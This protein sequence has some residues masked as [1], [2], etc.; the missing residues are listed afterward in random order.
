M[1]NLKYLLKEAG[2][3]W[4]IKGIIMEKKSSKERY[5]SKEI[6]NFSKKKKW[7]FSQSQNS[8]PWFY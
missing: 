8:L 5:T 7:N 6:S 4:P 2:W 3:L 1:Y